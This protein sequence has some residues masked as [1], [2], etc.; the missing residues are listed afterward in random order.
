MLVSAFGMAANIID[1]NGDGVQDVVKATALGTPQAV[2]VCYNNPA[3]V[4]FES[5]SWVAGAAG[6][7]YPPP[8]LEA[9]N[10]F[11]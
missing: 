8:G 5:V 6:L 2:N 1:M 11:R 4:G 3:S 7:K 10:S 9:R